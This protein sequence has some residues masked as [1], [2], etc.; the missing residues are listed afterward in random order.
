M[1]MIVYHELLVSVLEKKKMIGDIF[2]ILKE[3][4]SSF[5]IKKNFPTVIVFFLFLV[6]TLDMVSAY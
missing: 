3:L 5:D 4:C 6:C 2:K 1:G